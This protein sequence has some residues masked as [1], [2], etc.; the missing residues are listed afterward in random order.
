M[1]K[2]IDI[3]YAAGKEGAEI[4]LKGDDLNIRV[5]KAKTLSKSLIEEIRENKQ[6]IIQVLRNNLAGADKGEKRILKADKNS[7]SDTPLSFSQE[8]LWFVHQMEGSRQYHLTSRLLLKGKLN[9]EALSYALSTVVERHE[10]LR[11]IL[12]ENSGKPYQHVIPSAGWQMSIVDVSRAGNA[13][14]EINKL[15][16]ESDST[17]FDLAKDYMFRASLF[18]VSDEE[19]QLMITMH[20][21]ASD[22]WSFSIIVQEVTLLYQGFVERNTA[23]LP[24]L[25]LQFSDFAIWERCYLRKE[26]LDSKLDYWKNKLKNVPALQLPTDYPRPAVRGT[27][28]ASVKASLDAEV[29]QQ[30]IKLANQ[31]GCTLYI[32]LMAVYKVLLY[33]YTN[34]SDIAVG[35][36]LANRS[37]EDIKALVGFFVNTLTFRSQVDGNESFIDLL[38]QVKQTNLEAYQHSDVPFEKVVEAV[39]NERD[40]SRSPVFQV[41]LVFNNTP[42]ASGI[43]AGD[44]VIS[45]VENDVP[46]SKFDFTFFVSERNGQ[47]FIKAEYNKELFKKETMQGML[48]HFIGL[49]NSVVKAPNEKVGKLK[50]MGEAEE[51]NVLDALLASNAPLQTKK[52]V[53]D[54]LKDVMKYVTEFANEIGSIWE[55]TNKI[56][57]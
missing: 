52:S 9:I 17:P 19:H 1:K 38:Q 6:S 29:T 33:R 34:Q 21:V 22:A 5:P 14:E 57:A 28:G 47:L 53:V 36:S 16:S 42:K 27:Q 51:K 20:H 31:Q 7:S 41:M 3:L 49:L 24:P 46:V 35:A 13:E 4:S 32:L 11:T 10:V 8:R 37:Q 40:P 50:L 44:L 2:A 55:S 23:V 18:K 45:E 30:L 25:P 26:V 56:P 15:V 54:V 43:V 48:S 39:L 12:L